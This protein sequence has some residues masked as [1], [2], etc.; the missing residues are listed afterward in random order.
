MIGGCLL[1]LDGVVAEAPSVGTESAAAVIGGGDDSWCFMASAPG[2]GPTGATAGASAEIIVSTIFFLPCLILISGYFGGGLSNTMKPWRNSNDCRGYV[3]MPMVRKNRTKRND[4]VGVGARPVERSTHNA[5]RDSCHPTLFYDI[6]KPGTSEEKRSLS[7]LCLEY[8]LYVCGR[9]FS[10]IQSVG[11]TTRRVPRLLRTFF[12]SRKYN[13][14]LNFRDGGINAQRYPIPSSNIY[15]AIAL[16]SLFDSF[17][18]RAS[19]CDTI[20][21]ISSP[22]LKKKNQ[23][24]SL[25]ID[26][27]I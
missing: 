8:R 9:K 26:A 16:A 4:V 2:L 24:H 18:C 21:F 14:F 3:E 27:G 20:Q 17:L 12:D 15:V 11:N 19:R 13:F 22:T 25:K 10:P 6:Q 23:S 5:K 7:G 1:P